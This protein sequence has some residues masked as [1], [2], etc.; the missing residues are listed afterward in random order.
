MITNAEN[1][2]NWS[3]CDAVETS[4]SME[5]YE[6]RPLFVNLKSLSVSAALLI[7]VFMCASIVPLRK[8]ESF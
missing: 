4:F 2:F 8:C 5:N 6:S 3:R 1:A 7:F